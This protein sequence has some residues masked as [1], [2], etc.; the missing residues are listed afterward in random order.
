MMRYELFVRA[1]KR[2]QK[3]FMLDIDAI[4]AD[5]LHDMWDFL[6]T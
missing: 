6:K 1:T 2:G 5:T 3:S 4:T